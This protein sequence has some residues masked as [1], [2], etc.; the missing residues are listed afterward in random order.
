MKQVQL[1]NM[2]LFYEKVTSY[3]TYIKNEHRTWV[4]KQFGNNHSEH[5]AIKEIYLFSQVSRSKL[6]S[7]QKNWLSFSFLLLAP[8]HLSLSGEGGCLVRGVKL[9]RGVGRWCIRPQS[10]HSIAHIVLIWRKLSRKKNPILVRSNS[11]LHSL[12]EHF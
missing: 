9:F 11:I 8:N 2:S 3:I 6:K 1:I 4:I 10:G 7:K 5:E 12:Q